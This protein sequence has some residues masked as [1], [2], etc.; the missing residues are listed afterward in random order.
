MLD[1]VKLAEDSDALV[2][3]LYEAHGGAAR[4]AC[5]SGSRSPTRGA[6]NLL[7][8]SGPQLPVAGGT[9]EVAYRPHQVISL[10]VS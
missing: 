7:E 6:C 10:L 4:P 5:G 9:I 2:L 1:T 3:R 8:D